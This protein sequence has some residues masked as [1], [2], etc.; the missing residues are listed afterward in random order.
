MLKKIQIPAQVKNLFS[1]VFKKKSSENADEFSTT[2]FASDV[3]STDDEIFSDDLATDVQNFDDDSVGQDDTDFSLDDSF[4]A[5]EFDVDSLDFDS[6]D[7][8]GKKSENKSEKFAAEN[9]KKSFDFVQKLQ[10]FISENKILSIVLAS[11]LILLLVLIILLCVL[12]QVSKKAKEVVPENPEENVQL[13]YPYTL[14]SSEVLDEYHFSRETESQWSE[15]DALQW[16][17]D[18]SEKIMNDLENK[19]SQNIQKIL[20]SAP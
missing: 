8:D 2:D 7:V 6:L 16:Y 4:N 20:E 11:L 5:E 1:R 13:V 12:T 14:P 15:T 19:N 9:K 18:P 17:E 3:S 10:N